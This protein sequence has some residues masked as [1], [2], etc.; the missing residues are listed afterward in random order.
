[1]S[2]RN[3]KEIRQAAAAS[4]ASNRG[5]PQTVA[6][7]YAGIS[8]LLALSITV[9]SWLLDGRIAETGGLSNMGLR[10]ILSTVQFVLPFVQLVVMM[11]VGLGYNAVTLDIA[12]NRSAQPET[13]LVGFRKFFPLLRSVL[14]QSLI[15]FSVMVVCMYVSSWIFA[16]LPLSKDFYE[17]MAPYLESMTVMDS[18]LVMDD[19][20]LAAAASTMMPMV[21]II[22]LVYCVL[23]LP[24]IYQYRMV[25]YC[26]ADS[27]RPGA[28]A[29]LRDSR[30]MM[31]GNRL[32]LFR[33]DLG[34]WWYYLLQVLVTV[35]CYGD[36]LLPL[37]GVELP[38]SS[39]VS[40]FLFYV[41][42]Q[43]LQL[44]IFWF[45]MNR[46]QVT[47][48]TVYETLR[49]KPQTGGAVLG[50]IFDLARDYKED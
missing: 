18:G 24:I 23:A 42:S 33:L 46:V 28:F 4:L 15:Y 2:I 37:V 29:A 17:V 14:L 26:L 50:N 38:W 11:A 19:A 44:V 6:L 22:I 35:V 40:Y 32:N 41:L 7:I 20:T 16:A 36:L 12:R 8:C 21:W 34:F 27:D 48:A 30:I 5:R 1:M 47:Y 45:F 49:P 43:G 13:L 3:L 9:V 25:N 31:R 39:T 10:S